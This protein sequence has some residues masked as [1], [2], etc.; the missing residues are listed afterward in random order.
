MITVLSSSPASQNFVFVYKD[1]PLLVSTI[2]LGA[3]ALGIFAL[4]KRRKRVSFT[5]LESLLLTEDTSSTS[6]CI[7]LDYN[8]TTPINPLVLAAMLPFL[9]VHFGN[10][11]SSHF[12]GQQPKVAMTQARQHLLELIGRPKELPSSIW[13]TGCGTESDNLAIQLAVQSNKNKKIK[14]IVTTNVEHP[15]IAEC[16][17]SLESSNR[18]NVEVTY[19]PVET[20]GCVLAENIISAIR[21][22]TVLVTVML[23]NNESGALQPVA[24][25]AAACRER[26]I[27]MHTDA[28]QACGKVNVAE[29]VGEADMITIVGHKLGA[30]KGVAALY[31]RDGCCTCGDR[32]LPSGGILLM[33]GGQEGGRRGGTENVPYCVGLGKAAQLAVQNLEKNMKKMEALRTRLCQGLREQLPNAN[34]RV[35]GPIESDLRLPNTLSIGIAGIQS[36]NLLREIGDKVAASAGAACHSGGGGVSSILRAMQVPDEF[37]KGTLRLS[38]GPST[39]AADIDQAVILITKQVRIELEPSSEEK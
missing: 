5:D 22:N 24:E 12:Y 26:G 3:A 23:A 35:N 34:I 31:V 27:L 25:I 21:K 33:G 36:G 11:S 4:C 19:V 14:H 10:P 32:E 37:A 9:T 17:R 1:Q 7:Y 18:D 8:G 29:L 39:S 6:S 30:P 16:L 2:A 38:I 28:A 13:F 15:A 20:N